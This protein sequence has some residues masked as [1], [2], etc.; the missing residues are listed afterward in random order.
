MIII[1][2]SVS[3]DSLHFVQ[4]SH[5]KQFKGYAVIKKVLVPIF[6]QT[7]DRLFSIYIMTFVLK[8]S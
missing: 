8:M 3:V 2:F 7:I 4:N 5:V 6:K 1:C